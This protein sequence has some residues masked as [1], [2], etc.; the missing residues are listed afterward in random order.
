MI[1]DHKDNNKQNNYIGN[2]EWVNCHINTQRAMIDCCWNR[3]DRKQ[4]FSHIRY[5]KRG[6]PNIKTDIQ[7]FKYHICMNISGIQINRY[8]DTKEEAIQKKKQLY[9]IMIITNYI[10]YIKGIYPKYFK[11]NINF[12]DIDNEIKLI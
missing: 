2:L 6:N 8:V 5:V 4:N 7:N 3:K 10:R 11:L 9:A 12:K 1:I